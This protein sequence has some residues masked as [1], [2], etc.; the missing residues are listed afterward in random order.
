MI[1]FRPPRPGDPRDAA[2]IQAAFA[3]LATVSS[4]VPTEQIAP[5]G[6]D[7]SRLPVAPVWATIAGANLTI[8]TRNPAAIAGSGAYVQLVHNATPL[9][10]TLGAP[11]TLAAGE[12]LRLRAWLRFASSVGAGVGLEGDFSAR[13]Y[14]SSG[15]VIPNAVGVIERKGLGTWG[16]CRNNHGVLW[17]EAVL[18][19]PLSRT[20]AELRYTYVP[21]GA[22]DCYID[23]VRMWATR[24]NRWA[25]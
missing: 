14:D 1:S 8:A 20:W 18:V 19:G 23:R 2:Q 6:I 16:H 21:G 3:A 15:V 22:G 12:A 25:T 11:L 17:V 7:R 5:E 13:W 9:R 10:I 4:A 24:Y